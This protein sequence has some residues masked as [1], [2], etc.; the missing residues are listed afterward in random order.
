MINCSILYSSPLRISKF[1]IFVDLKKARF[2][3][4]TTDLALKSPE[5]CNYAVDK[6]ALSSSSVVMMMAVIVIATIVARATMMIA[7]SGMVGAASTMMMSIA[8]TTTTTATRTRRTTG[9]RSCW[10]K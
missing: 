9:G 6:I 5:M 10:R 4:Y 3:I 2:P 7:T 8:T 1:I